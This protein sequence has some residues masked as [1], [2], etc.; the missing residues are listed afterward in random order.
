MDLNMEELDLGKQLMADNYPHIPFSEIEVIQSGGIKTIWK[1]STSVGKVC[2]KRIRKTIPIVK[3]TTAAQAYL[4]KKGALVADII[5][6]KD[7]QLFF[8]HEGYALVLYA[9]IEGSD[10][11]MDKV[12]EHLYTG[13]KGL[14]QFHQDS[15]GFIPPE[16]CDIYDR[17]GVWPDH[18][19]KM[20][21]ELSQWKCV[22]QAEPEADAF[23]QLYSNTADDMIHMANEAIQLLQ[24]SYY[25]QWVASIG[26]YGYLC[27]Q[28]YGKGNALE[29]EHGVYV[30][31]LD[32]VTYDIPLRDVRKLIAKRMEE[33][34]SWDRAELERCMGY[35][36]SIFPLTADQRKILYID[37]LFPHKY[38]GYVKSPFKKGE[39]GD[40]NKLQKCIR[41]ET[42]KLPV[43]H[44]LLNS[45]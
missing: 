12:P 40:E 25:S 35:Y 33:L 37:L 41:I 11:A 5:P 43:L 1:L 21:E 14:A 34:G 18:Y 8:V 15:V 7:N 4:S 28:D 6:T 42:E 9:W 32:N 45:N 17:M 29:T 10:L 24:S 23:H 36:E 31:D 39:P 26:H 20:C 19:M 27:H 2:L 30:L 22:S 3:F 16:D 44:S 38:Y 13:L